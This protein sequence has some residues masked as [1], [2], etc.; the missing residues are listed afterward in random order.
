MRRITRWLY[1]VILLVA[2]LFGFLFTLEN[3][4]PVSVTLLGIT[5]PEWEL[6]I[7]LLVTLCLGVATG[8]V[9]SVL[10]SWSQ[11]H[12]LA[13]LKRRNAELEREVQLLRSQSL[14]D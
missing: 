2:L 14:R 9:V 4:L 13:A 10:P 3:A 1:V 6:G 12:K 5:L 11:G 8:F 7:W